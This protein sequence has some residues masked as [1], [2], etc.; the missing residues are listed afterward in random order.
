MFLHIGTMK[1]GTSYLQW[2]LRRNKDSL[3]EAGVLVPGGVM[4]AAPD[5]LERRGKSRSKEF[6]GDWGRVVDKV[7]EWQGGRAIV[8]HELLS[9]AEEEDA[10]RLMDTLPNHK[11]TVIITARDLARILPSHWQTTV[12]RDSTWTFAEFTSI[13]L[14]EPA[15]QRGTKRTHKG[16]WKHHDLARMVDV[17]ASVV[18]IENV[19]IITVPPPGAPSD[20]LWS[21][22]CSVV[23]VDPAAYDSTPDAKANASLSYAE[24]EMLRQVNMVVKKPLSPV[25]HRELVTG[26]VANGMLRTLPAESDRSTSRAQLGPESH[27]Q[28]V[29]RS[30]SMLTALQESGVRIVGDIEELRVAPYAGD[31]DHDESVGPT[32]AIPPTVAHIISELLLKIARLE[33]DNAQ[34]ARAE[35][36]APARRGGR[37]QVAAAT[38]GRRAASA[39]SRSRPGQGG[40]RRAVVPATADDE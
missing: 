19:V 36:G 24:T 8:S 38:N 21:R 3:A 22:F 20:L 9:A 32:D 15:G 39:E 27:A 16:F 25:E 12:K 30:N 6:R 2:V 40:R 4:H 33:R 31:P 10:R 13:L 17:W 5:I 18:G 14:T 26:Y 29:Q 34:A 1:S 11:V 37:K 35:S 28:V 23:G 7:D